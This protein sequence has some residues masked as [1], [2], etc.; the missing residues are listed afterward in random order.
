MRHC[1]GNHKYNYTNGWKLKKQDEILFDET[2]LNMTTAFT[3]FIKAVVRQRKIPFKI[4]ADP[5]YSEINQAHLHKAISS[6]ES[7]KVNYDIRSILSLFPIVV[8]I[9]AKTLLVIHNILYYNI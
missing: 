6:L 9:I 4:T 3:F 5:F 8:N 1:Y 2:G 7:G